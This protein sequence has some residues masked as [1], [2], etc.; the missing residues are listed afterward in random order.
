M[1]L[2][3]LNDLDTEAAH[4]ALLQ[5][6]GSQK[7]ARRVSGLRPFATIDEVL[8]AAEDVG[9]EL[10]EQD[11]LEAFAAHPR[12]G[13]KSASAWA[14]AEQAAALNADQSVQQ[15]LAAANAE[16]EKRF[17]FI[18]IVFATGKTPQEI[19]GLLQLRL[20]NDR[21]TEIRNAA[22]E[23]R[24]ITRTRLRKLMDL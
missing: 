22:T 7:W 20:L 1:T 8:R 4:S 18:F 13:E 24:H 3:D 10:N 9:D 21:S 5:C 15:A 6:C 14:Q 19:L 16:Y 11:W 17:G 23:Q 2:H 12:I